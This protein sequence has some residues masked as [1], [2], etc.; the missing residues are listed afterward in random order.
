LFY[1]DQVNIVANV[2]VR[3]VGNRIGSLIV[4]AGLR[5]L[6]PAIQEF[7]AAATHGAA[8]V[9]GEVPEYAAFDPYNN[10]LTTDADPIAYV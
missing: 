10:V 6:Y 2:D 5:V 9:T 3:L 1:S 7:Y 4:S 8:V